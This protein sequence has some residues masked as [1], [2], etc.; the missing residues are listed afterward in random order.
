MTKSIIINYLKGFL[1]IINLTITVFFLGGLMILI[2]PVKLFLLKSIYKEKI[3]K[4][5]FYIA[6]SWIHYN[7][8]IFSYLHGFRWEI[9]F[10]K[11]MKRN[12]K[13]L[14]I[15]NHLSSA[16]I[17]AIFILSYKRI[18]FPRF[19]LKQELLFIPFFGQALWTLEM[20]VM[21]RFTKEY[22]KKNPQKIG[23]DLNTTKKSCDKLHG[24]PF[25]II[26]FVEG[27]R[28]NKKK[29]IDSYYK[30]LLMP[31]VGGIHIVITELGDQLD[32]IL[33]IT[34]CYPGFDSPSFGDIIFGKVKKSLIIVDQIK[35][36]TDQVLK[37]IILHKNKNRT[38]YW[39]NNL[40]VKKDK[41]L[42]ELKR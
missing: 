9:K 26:N 27:T 18:P 8:L 14:L 7:R 17:L 23:A 34:I 20:P 1:I 2:A 24:K 11:K 35:I 30:N 38:K 4:L 39:L 5:L 42:S 22:L 19:F 33:D 36:E 31:R 10:E 40:W 37:D 3:Q 25:T 41:I 13:Y 6:W 16:D 12:G 28:F 15:S 32:A 21:K 29:I